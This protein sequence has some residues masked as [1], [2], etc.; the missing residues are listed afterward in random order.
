MFY[1]LIKIRQCRLYPL[2]LVHF[3]LMWV[4]EKNTKLMIPAWQATQVFFSEVRVR[5]AVT[6]CL[7]EARENVDPL[8][9]V[10][11][12]SVCQALHPLE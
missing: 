9:P 1:K 5:R 12:N 3:L 10:G 2:V 4:S 7:M 6:W 11:G 8:L